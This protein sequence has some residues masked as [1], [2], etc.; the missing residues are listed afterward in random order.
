[1]ALKNWILGVS[2]MTLLVA[3]AAPV[4]QPN[5][6]STNLSASSQT[7]QAIEIDNLPAYAI[8]PAGQNV[9]LTGQL[10]IPANLILSAEELSSI[11]APP[12]G[13]TAPPQ[14][15]TAPPQGITAPPMGI[16][17]AQPIFGIRSVKSA[18]LG[19][20]F[21]AEFF[22][23]NFKLSLPQLNQTATINQTVIQYINGQPYF[24]AS[25]MLPA[26][27][28]GANYK[29]EASHPLLNLQ[30]QLTT[31]DSGNT[32]AADLDLG[33]TAVN[34]VKDTAA[35][36]NKK[37]NLA[38]L[39]SHIQELETTVASAMQRR[40]KE[41]IS[42]TELQ[43]VVNQFVQG[44]PAYV[45]PSKIEIQSAVK[46]QVK[47]GEKLLLNATTTFA[48]QSTTQSALWQTSA[49]DI[50]NIQ[51][52]GTLLA[53]KPGRITVAAQAMDNATLRSQIVVDIVP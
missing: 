52:D 49:G 4:A 32:L 12:Q 2:S 43:K 8:K 48:D 47:V 41:E 3:C 29:L 50:G 18:A 37:V 27:K 13:I 1:M 31:G 6:P 19:T 44:L 46:R 14:G 16:L 45:E 15:I 53:L 7:L 35:K 39:S 28:P 22:R 51:A 23:D 30:T 9:S 42:E 11:T 38:Y 36:L 21:W 26:L 10:R 40:F 25:Y 20:T 5:Q 17:P 24:V 33:S 34:L